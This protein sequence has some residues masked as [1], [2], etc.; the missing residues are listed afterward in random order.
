MA[1]LLICTSLLMQLASAI[2]L[3]LGVLTPEIV[4][5][6][7]VRVVG[8]ILAKPN[9]PLLKLAHARIIGSGVPAQDKSTGL[10]ELLAGLLSDVVERCSIAFKVY[11]LTYVLAEILSLLLV[12]GLSLWGLLVAALATHARPLLLVLS[13]AGLLVSCGGICA[14]FGP[15]KRSTEPSV[16]FA[17]LLAGVLRLVSS[18]WSLTYPLRWLMLHLVSLFTILMPLAWYRSLKAI[19]ERGVS[20]AATLVGLLLLVVSTAL[21]LSVLFVSH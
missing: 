7:G 3:S 2:L 10:K 19:H 5:S 12:F 21:Q 6:V 17:S 18:A 4:R 11:A 20:W 16:T 15:S 1:K 8:Y 9:S 13:I 14:I